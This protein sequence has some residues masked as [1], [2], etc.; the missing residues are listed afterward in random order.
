MKLNVSM[1]QHSQYS[2]QSIPSL[3][4]PGIELNTLK[5]PAEC[6]WESEFSYFSILHARTARGWSNVF[7]SSKPCVST[8]K[9]STVL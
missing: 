9:D 4:L 6:H 8:I 5:R 1:H 2:I 3:R 7:V